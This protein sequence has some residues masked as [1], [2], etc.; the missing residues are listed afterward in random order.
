MVHA[1]RAC[2]EPKYQIM[3]QGV[4]HV[5]KA[6]L[7]PC[8]TRDSSGPQPLLNTTRDTRESS[9]VSTAS[10]GSSGA[11]DHTWPEMRPPGRLYHIVKEEQDRLDLCRVL[12]GQFDNSSDGKPSFRD[13]AISPS[14]VTD[15]MP[16]TYID[17]LSQLTSG[18]E[19]GRVASRYDIV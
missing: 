13:I 11:V 7:L 18:P 4:A 12:P 10:S 1:L 19:S 2:Q 3:F 16:Q 15:H 5:L 6:C 17:A 9:E 14:M 8:C